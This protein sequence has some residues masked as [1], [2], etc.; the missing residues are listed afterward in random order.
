[1]IITVT[2][3]PALDKTAN[4]D[5][6]K[7]GGLNRLHDLRLDAG[8]KGLNVSSVISALGGNSIATGFVG[9]GSGAELLSLVSAKG[10]NAD[11]LRIA[12][13]TRTNLK[14]IDSEGEL[15]ELNEPGPKISAAEWLEMERKLSAYAKSTNTIILSGSLPSGLGIDT[16]Q[17]LTT[18]LRRSGA[19]VFLDADGE[20][21]KLALKSAPNEIPNY[22]KPNRYELLQYFNRADN[23][24]TTEAELAEL[25]RSLL[26]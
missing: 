12:G 8:G 3:N 10:L 7:T 22:I 19:A 25:C 4:V 24:R 15:T 6:M 13:V 20:A 21:L 11:F 2:L 23:E 1:M 14:V 26:E 5:K 9:G 16:Y 18:L 17:K